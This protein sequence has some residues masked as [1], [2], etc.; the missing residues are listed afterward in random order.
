MLNE[1]DQC[2]IDVVKFGVCCSDRYGTN[3]IVCDLCKK[4]GVTVYVSHGGKDLCVLCHKKVSEFVETKVSSEP[5]GYYY[6]NPNTEFCT[7]TRWVKKT[8]PRPY[9]LHPDSKP[10]TKMF[11]EMFSCSVS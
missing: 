10:V 5:V 6:L 3:K 1:T 4:S 9:S 2:L 8:T 11:Q 7:N